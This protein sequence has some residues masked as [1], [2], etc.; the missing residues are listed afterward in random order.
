MGSL[1]K[2]IEA[3]LEPWT[4][5]GA[6]PHAEAPPAAAP[7]AVA[8]RRRN[9]ASAMGTPATRRH[10]ASLL[11][12]SIVALFL[13]G[14]RAAAQTLAV[15][16][17]ALLAFKAA[18]D[19][20]GDLVS[21]DSATSPCAALGWDSA[22]A[23][24]L[25]VT[26]DAEGGRVT[27]LG[28]ENSLT[29]KAGLLGTVESLLPLTA[30]TGLNFR[31]CAAVSGDVS[32]LAGLPQL[33]FIVLQSPSMTGSMEPLASLPLQILDLRSCATVSGSVEIL[34]AAGIPGLTQLDLSSTGV[35]GS[36]E[37][38]ALCP[39]L[40]YVNL[41]ST[42]VTGSVETL[43]ALTGLT[44]LIL[45]TT[46]VSGSVEILAAGI[47]GITE[48]DLG[49]TGVTGSVEALALCRGLTFVILSSTAVTGSVE[50]L[51]SLTQMTT[52][53][54]GATSVTSSVEPLASLTLL[55]HLSLAGTQVYGNASHIRA[56]AGL[57]TWG[58]SGS[59]F[60]S[61]SAYSTCPASAD[62]VA[63]A[64]D[65]VGADTCACCVPSTGFT[66]AEAS[67]TCGTNCSVSHVAPAT[68]GRLGSR[69]NV[70]ARSIDHGESCD[71][72][73]NAGY[74]VNSSTQP[75][76]TDGNLSSTTSVCTLQTCNIS[77]VTAP[78]NGSFGTSVCLNSSETM[79][80][81][82][83]CDLTC[84]SGY[85][86]IDQPRCVE[87]N[88][89]STT[90]TCVVC[91]DDPCEA[92][93]CY[94][95]HGNASCTNVSSAVNVSYVSVVDV[96]TNISSNISLNMSLNVTSS[97]RSNISYVSYVIM[98]LNEAI[99]SCDDEFVGAAYGDTDDLTGCALINT[100]CTDLE[101]NNTNPA[102]NVDDFSCTYATE[103]FA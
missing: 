42:A 26:C 30:L 84:G 60:T 38:L 54:L 53:S 99:C 7:P 34:V 55:T 6:R 31:G 1:P 58:T 88:L 70:T 57:S 11:L 81:G 97:V 17:A 5:C 75:A 39:G 61:C 50:A 86:V 28:G 3:T 94:P 8:S 52:L 21:W 25:G 66:R 76:C 89:T 47:P 71:L 95:C 91:P 14:G 68:N 98:A 43:T 48:L 10:R 83:S 77:S 44:T 67:G 32:T 102:A 64:S 59:D 46:S 63:N 4:R 20:D 49:A 80:H 33:T 78:I 100:G 56:I 19:P 41:M 51:A 74:T 2:S 96:S 18:G 24:W 93:P 101:A 35:A 36:V 73:C 69:C 103:S 85:S 62:L 27:R 22:T 40:S 82:E 15:D 79:N 29:D 65:Y 9:G 92:G 90:A 23:G 72:V 87:G 13:L 45:R 16:E 37:A 12:Q